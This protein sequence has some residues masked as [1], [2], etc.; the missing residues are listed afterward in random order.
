MIFL[1]TNVVSEIMRPMPDT[2]VLTWLKRNED[3][4]AL[5]TIAI[6]EISFGIESIRPEERSHRLEKTF[7]ALRGR[8][9][10]RIYDFD[11]ISALAYGDFCGRRKREGEAVAIADGMIAAIALRHKAQLATRNTRHFINSGLK[12]INPWSD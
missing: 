9:N 11:E 5:S 7:K 2:T 8:L 10:D 4:L 3:Q 1:D 6:A 12:L